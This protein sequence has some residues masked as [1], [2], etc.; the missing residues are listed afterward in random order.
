LAKNCTETILPSVSDAFAVIRTGLFTASSVA[1][2]GEGMRTVGGWPITVP[3]P[4]PPEVIF[5]LTA[6]ETP[7]IPTEFVAR[8][9]IDDGRT[10]PSASFFCVNVAVTV[11][12]FP[13]EGVVA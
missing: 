6:G 4:L 5:T 1:A 2:T 8:A 3:V 11:N 9:V 7:V 12:R 13:E 10:L